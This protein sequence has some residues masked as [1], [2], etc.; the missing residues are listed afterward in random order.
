MTFKKVK[1]PHIKL[2]TLTKWLVVAGAVVAVLLLTVAIVHHYKHQQTL[3]TQQHQA[4]LQ[5]AEQKGYMKGDAHFQSA[6]TL[7]TLQTLEC[8]KGLVAYNALPK[9]TQQKTPQPQC[10][11]EVL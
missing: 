11:T 7:Y 8:K 4:E 10:R 6:N 5:A 3:L 2:T 9:A 1:L